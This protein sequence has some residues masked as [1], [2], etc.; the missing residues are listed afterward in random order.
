MHN[1][2]SSPCQTSD[3]Q[4]RHSSCSFL[5]LDTSPHCESHGGCFSGCISRDASATDYQAE[6]AFHVP[7]TR[8]RCPTRHV[9]QSS[10][11]DAGAAAQ[12]QKRMKVDKNLHLFQG[13]KRRDDVAHGKQEMNQVSPVPGQV[14]G[15]PGNQRGW[16]RWGGGHVP[17]RVQSTR[18]TRW[19]WWQLIRPFL[20]PNSSARDR[21]SCLVK[22]GTKGQWPG[23]TS[24]AP[25]PGHVDFLHPPGP[26]PPMLLGWFLLP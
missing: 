22:V 14:P 3:S 8:R 11:H 10:P 16:T 6:P 5:R 1:S 9:R 7:L 21:R 20:H 13:K 12:T 23:W 4:R 2:V 24:P 26:G 15:S 25:L 18:S 19:P 17:A